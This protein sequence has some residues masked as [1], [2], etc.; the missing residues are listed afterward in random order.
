MDAKKEGKSCT[1][2]TRVI[3]VP[4]DFQFALKK[5]KKMHLT[6]ID[7]KF[8]ITTCKA[9][10]NISSFIFDHNKTLIWNLLSALK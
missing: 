2:N 3:Y 7:A 10:I 4:S 8:T 6:W 1:S 5:K 9:G